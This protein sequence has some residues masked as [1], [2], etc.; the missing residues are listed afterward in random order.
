MLQTVHYLFG[1]EAMQDTNF[2]PIWQRE[3]RANP[4]AVY[5]RMRQKDPIWKGVGPVTGNN[6]WFFVRYED[7]QNVLKDQRFV[8]DFT[9]NLP[10]QIAK[11]Y[12]PDNPNPMFDA[13]NRHLLNLDAPDHTRLRALVHK[14]FTPNRVRDLEP[15]IEAIAHDLLDKMAAKQDANLIEDFA[16]PLPITVIAEMLG[17]HRERR[18]DFRRWTRTLLFGVDEQQSLGAVMEFMQYMNELIEIRRHQEMNDILGALV[19]VEEGG[20]ALDHMELLSMIF[21]LLVAGHE[22]TVNLIGNG[23]LALMQNPEQL[24]LLKNEMSLM[25]KAIEELL[26][27]NGP[28]ETPTTRWASEDIEINGCV[29]PLGDMVLPSLLAAN[30]DPDVFKNPDQLDITRDPNPHI[31]FG[32]GI[33]YCLG[34]PLA[35]MEGQ[36]AMKALLERFPTIRLNAPVESLEWSENLLLH[37]M[38]ALPV[39]W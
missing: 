32:H 20:D 3:S 38:A 31:A 6:F 11:K 29:I 5:E 21:L 36:I 25:P 4:Q 14:A 7:V 39:A 28:V 33:H 9:K 13:I 12:I 34:A 27:Y 19:R 16:F 24:E 26:R 8:K 1:G 37:G 35:R 2:Y 22:T 15:R 23:T 10:P 17:V 18:D 30:R